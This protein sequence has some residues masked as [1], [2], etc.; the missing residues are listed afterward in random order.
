MTEAEWLSGPDPYDL[1]EQCLICELTERRLRLFACACCRRLWHL[2]EDSRLCVAIEVAERYADSEATEQELEATRDMAAAFLENYV[3]QYWADT[4]LI[5]DDTDI[6][7]LSTEER[8]AIRMALERH[9]D[10]E[11]EKRWAVRHAAEA[12]VAAAS[13]DGDDGKSYLHHAE[14]VILETSQAQ[15]HY[16]GWHAERRLQA[17]LLR[18]IFGNPYR[19][20]SFNPRWKSRAVIDLARIIDSSRS[21]DRILALGDALEE[22]GCDSAEVLSHCRSDTGH[23]LGCWVVD[24]ILGKA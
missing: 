24:A 4:E 17:N 1:L 14:T 20:P 3:L 15:T 16:V 2:L 21:F 23:V 12:V 8:D 7:S 13:R 9:R 5:T 11:D 18:D 10:G 22:A 6:D 19:L